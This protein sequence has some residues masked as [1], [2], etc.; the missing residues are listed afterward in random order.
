M[1]LILSHGQASVERGFSVNKALEVEN[2]KEASYISQRVIHEYI[3][4]SGEIHN[5]QITKEIRIAASSAR[6]KYMHMQHLEKKKNE[7]Q[8]ETKQLKR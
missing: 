6:S 1:I 8:A 4:L 5:L 2:L 7:A 3:K